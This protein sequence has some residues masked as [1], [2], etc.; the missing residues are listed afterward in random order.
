MAFLFASYRLMKVYVMLYAYNIIS[1]N[2]KCIYRKP[3]IAAHS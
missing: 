1:S 2:I 3:Y